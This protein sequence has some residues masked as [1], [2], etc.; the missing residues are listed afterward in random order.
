MN[1]LQ[2][3][4]L[5]ARTPEH[6]ISDV[7]IVGVAFSDTRK[8]ASASTL[9][10]IMIVCTSQPAIVLRVSRT[11]AAALPG[12]HTIYRYPLLAARGR[13]RYRVTRVFNMLL[14]CH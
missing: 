14:T 4:A 9:Q 12:S 7:A 3:A 1:A 2:P 13:H 8:S 6:L 10:D 5:A 11:I